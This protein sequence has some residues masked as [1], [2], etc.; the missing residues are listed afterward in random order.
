MKTVIKDIF[1]KQMLNIQKNYLIFMKTYHSYQK[2][3]KIEKVKKIVCG[4]EDKK[5]IYVVHINALKEALNHGLIF[6][7]LHRV[8]QFIQKKHG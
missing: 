3:K 1:F 6:K 5:K 7:K 8:T 2:E 4:I